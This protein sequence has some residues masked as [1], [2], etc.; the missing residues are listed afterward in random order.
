MGLYTVRIKGRPG[1]LVGI[2]S[3]DSAPEMEVSE[4]C[5]E[6]NRRG[7]I[8]HVHSDTEPHHGSEHFRAW[9]PTAEWHRKEAARLESVE[10]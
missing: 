4:I 8:W 1:S 9:K 2:L 5:E 10:R 7:I 3:L 6:C